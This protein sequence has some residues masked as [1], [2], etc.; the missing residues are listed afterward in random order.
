[1]F[2]AENIGVQCTH[3]HK[4]SFSG[5]DDFLIAHKSAGFSSITMP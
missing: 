4:S 2:T 1:M 5:Y 3:G